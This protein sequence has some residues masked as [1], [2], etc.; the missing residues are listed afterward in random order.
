MKVREAKLSDANGIALVHVDSWR[1]TYR[2]ILP[3]EYLMNLSYKRRKQLWETNIPKG[4]VFVAE[5]DE[6]KI[7]GFASGGKERS[8]KYKEYEGELSSIY[9]LEEYQGQGI[10]RL[11]VKSVIKEIQ[12]SGI[13]TMLVL[14]LE[15]NN[16]RRFYEAIGGKQINKV[17]VEIAGKKINEL[18]YGWDNI[19]NIFD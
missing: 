10:G 9:I 16:S 4:N 5:N 11:L 3:D 14:V 17:V 8:G 13:N 12:N 18:V 19:R 7:V 1:T 6:G 2:S 15:E